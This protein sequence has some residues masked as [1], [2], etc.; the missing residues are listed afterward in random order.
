MNLR[1]WARATH[2]MRSDPSCDSQARYFSIT[3]IEQILRL[4]I[5]ALT[6]SLNAGEDLRVD[7]FG[8][9]WVDQKQSYTVVS[10][11]GGKS[12]KIRIKN[13]KTIHFKA[14]QQLLAQLNQRGPQSEQG[15]K[16]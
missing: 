5:D 14:S 9:I 7:A 2:K 10:N 15:L 13:R 8:H 11:L 12:Q 1:E 16:C 3:E 6:M 4:G